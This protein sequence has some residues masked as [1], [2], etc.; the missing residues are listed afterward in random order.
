MD[1][2][3]AADFVV[4]DPSVP[5]GSAAHTILDNSGAIATPKSLETDVKAVLTKVSLGEA[6]AGIVYV[7]DARV[8]GDK[9]MALDIAPDVNVINPYFIG[10]V[11]G[12]DQSDL[13]ETWVSLVLSPAGQ[14][15]LATAGF[16]GP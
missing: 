13:A 16:G 2:L 10:V 3:A 4:C 1:D 7:T 8:A 9:V 15:V 5:C 6:D 12:S 11:K 14:A